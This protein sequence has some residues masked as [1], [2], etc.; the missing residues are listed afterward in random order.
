MSAVMRVLI[1]PEAQAANR[2]LLA[3]RG[4][5]LLISLMNSFAD[6]G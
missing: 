4:L 1:G 5:C 2:P 3:C 6:G